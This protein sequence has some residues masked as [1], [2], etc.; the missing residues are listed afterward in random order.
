MTTQRVP[1]P[2]PGPK[3]SAIAAAPTRQAEEGWHTFETRHPEEARAFMSSA[4][5]V[6]QVQMTGR[7]AGFEFSIR[8]RHLE[9]FCVDL[10]RHTQHL[11][12]VG[13]PSHD[14]YVTEVLEGHM[15]VKGPD[16]TITINAGHAV[17][18]A[19]DEPREI[20][21]DNVRLAVV[22]LD[23]LEMRRLAGRLVGAD[24]ATVRFRLSRAESW[25]RARQWSAALRYVVR[26]VLDNPAASVSPIAQRESFHLLATTALEAFPQPDI[27][28]TRHRPEDEPVPA[29]A[30]V[31]RAIEFIEANAH[32]DISVTD[33]AKA[34]GM[35]A[36]GIQAN[37]Q[38]HLNTSPA[39]YLR[40]VRLA[41]AH[42]DLV[43]ADPT[44][45][46]GVAEIAARWGFL[47]PGRFAATYR[48]CYGVPPS[49]TLAR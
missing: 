14:I 30:T 42:R 45:G 47:H 22:R 9:L 2:E 18:T 49:H 29:P 26:G 10:V 39:A 46:P 28:I 17:M 43:A 23:A 32:R 4:Y 27:S 48:A 40:S 19:A 41:A 38:R 20:S 12:M 15:R 11:E 31:R 7:P 8:S 21:W 33:I 1:V 35:S 3:P 36:R 44:T 37:F 34:A 13:G 6:R 25:A 5:R 24:P 16:S